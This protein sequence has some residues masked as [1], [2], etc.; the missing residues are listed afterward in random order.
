MSDRHQ[1]VLDFYSRHPIS[2]EHIIARL[3]AD[4]GKLADLGP[5]TLFTHDQDHYGGLEANDAL[6]Q[7][8]HLKPGMHVAD[9]CAGLG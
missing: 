5:E 2:A 8:A 9:F 1:H 4:R 3:E 6:A 7:R